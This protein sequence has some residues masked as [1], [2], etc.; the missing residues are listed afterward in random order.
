MNLRIDLLWNSYP[1]KYFPVLG[2]LDLWNGISDDRI[3]ICWTLK[4]FLSF[5]LK[6]T[7]KIR[8]KKV[9]NKNSFCN[10][11]SINTLLI[12]Q[13]NLKMITFYLSIDCVRF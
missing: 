10:E 4:P 8:S 1:K 2:E 11:K 5:F 12:A 9:N 13:F 3:T 6:V 7:S